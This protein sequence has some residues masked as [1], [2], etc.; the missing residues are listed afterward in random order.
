[1]WL[2]Q[3]HRPSIASTAGAPPRKLLDAFLGR[4]RWEARNLDLGSESGDRGPELPLLL[5]E[6]ANARL[7]RASS[8][9]VLGASWDVVAHQ[10]LIRLI[11]RLMLKIRKIFPAELHRA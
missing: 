5:L 4:R 11:D 6:S 3:W 9:A 8:T 7:E 10:S 1:M 2:L